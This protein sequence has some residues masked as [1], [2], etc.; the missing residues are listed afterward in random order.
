ML[1][2]YLLQPFLDLVHKNDL[3]DFPYEEVEKIIGYSFKNK[4]LLYKAFKHR[5]YLSVTKEPAWES[6]ERLEFLGDAVVDL[7]VTVALHNDHPEESEGSLSKMKSVLVSRKVLAE[8]LS[9][10]NVGRFLLLNKGELKTGGANRMS[11]IANLYEA[12]V[13]AIYLDG[14]LEPAFDFLQDTL[15]W[16]TDNFLKQQKFQNYKS[17]LLEFTQG[18]GMGSPSYKL[19]SESGPDHDKQF[20]M[21]VEIADNRSA[22]GTGHSKKIAEQNAAKHLLKNIAPNLLK[23]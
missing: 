3:P 14:G 13:G 2:K 4:L 7:I 20:F 22:K 11:N 10:L 21:R 1:K 16:Q 15:L 12:V 8:V 23:I 18:L 9:E 5:S 19:E 6:N 17:I